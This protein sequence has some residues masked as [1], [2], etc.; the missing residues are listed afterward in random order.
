MIRFCPLSP[1]MD[2]SMCQTLLLDLSSREN[3]CN[4]SIRSPSHRLHL[5]HFLRL[6][7]LYFL[8]D[9]P[10]I[11]L[12]DQLE[13][14]HALITITNSYQEFQNVD[15]SLLFYAS[16]PFIGYEST[17]EAVTMLFANSS[18]KEKLY[19]ILRIK[20]VSEV[21]NTCQIEMRWAAI[22]NTSQI[23]DV[24]CSRYSIIAI[25]RAT[26]LFDSFL[27]AITSSVQVPK[28]KQKSMIWQFQCSLNVFHTII[29]VSYD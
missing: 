13:N 9:Q 2:L 22:A 1:L 17:K 24:L 7:M 28:R 26:V 11:T 14:E 4:R 29:Q 21:E 8:L 16:S 5:Q 15:G 10:V 12:N 20:N 23:S 27:D 18:I 6:Y 3:R 19:D 25:Q